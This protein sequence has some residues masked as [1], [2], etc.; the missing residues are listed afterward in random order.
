M[1]E[2]LKDTLNVMKQIRKST[3]VCSKSIAPKNNDKLGKKLVSTY[4]SPKW[5]GTKCP[6]E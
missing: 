2:H 1:Y 4:A 5:D 6:E 3:K